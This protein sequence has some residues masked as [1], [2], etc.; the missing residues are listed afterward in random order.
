MIL[1]ADGMILG[2]LASFAAERALLGDNV[3]IVNCEKALVTGNKSN[4]LKRY[5]IKRKKGGPLHGPYF[6]RE[7]HMIM[8]RTIRGMLPFSQDK[9]RNAFRRVKCHLGIPKNFEGEDLAKVEYAD[10]SR[11]QTKKYITLGELSRLLGA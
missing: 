7:A 3:E 8:K 10:K 9:G 5:N 6:P 2:R 11:L 4:V 1:N